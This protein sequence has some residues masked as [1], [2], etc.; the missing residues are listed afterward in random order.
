MAKYILSPSVKSPNN[1]WQA[2][3]PPC[4][5]A[6][7]LFE[8]PACPWSV[9]KYHINLTPKCIRRFWYSQLLTAIPPANWWWLG[10]KVS[11]LMLGYDQNVLI[12]SIFIKLQN[13]LLNH[14]QPFHNPTPVEHLGLDWKVEYTNANQGIMPEA[15]NIWV[16][17]TQSEENNLNNTFQ[18]RI[19]CFP[20][21]YFSWSPPNQIL[22]FQERLPAGKAIS[23]ISKR[24]KITQ[25]WVLCPQ[26][27]ECTVVISTK[28]KDP[29]CWAD[30]FDGFILVVKQTNKMH[31]VPVGA[32]VW[33]AHSVRGNAALGGINS[34][35]LVNNH[36]DLDTYWTVY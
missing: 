6:G 1:P 25:Q 16:Q 33:P 11:G 34:G 30:C 32:I 13:G 21:V 17:Y 35:R 31:I 29:H 4:I 18:G 5:T 3:Y 24:C 22:Q 7:I 10:H 36:V 8:R 19:P 23:T 12:D 26:A 20:V 27:H 28:Y 15:H 14:H 9:Q 2:H